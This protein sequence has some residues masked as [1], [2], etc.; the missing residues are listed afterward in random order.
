MSLEEIDRQVE[1][2]LA[3]MIASREYARVLKNTEAKYYGLERRN[4]ECI[5]GG[6]PTLSTVESRL[7]KVEF[8]RSEVSYE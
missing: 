5:P 7:N 4:I 8:I 2:K 1:E 3:S 6:L